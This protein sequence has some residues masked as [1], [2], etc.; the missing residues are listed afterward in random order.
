[1][2]SVTRIHIKSPTRSHFPMS[3]KKLENLLQSGQNSDLDRLIQRAQDMD[4]LTTALRAGIEPDLA[5]NL[6]AANVQENRVLAIICSSS[7][8][9]ARFRFESERLIEIAASIGVTAQA[10]IVKVSR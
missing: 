8:W 6:V 1:M 5:E 7:T 4:T 9:A 3:V 10:C 2:I